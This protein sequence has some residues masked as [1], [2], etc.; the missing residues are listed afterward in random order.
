LEAEV[1]TTNFP[2]WRG[3]AWRAWDARG[4]TRHGLFAGAEPAFAAGSLRAGLRVEAVRGGRPETLALLGLRTRRAA[5]WQLAANATVP[6]RLGGLGDDV[7]W[8]AVLT[9]T[10]R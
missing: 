1:R 10:G 8:S 4:P 5:G 6:G 2:G 3:T 9:G 7:R